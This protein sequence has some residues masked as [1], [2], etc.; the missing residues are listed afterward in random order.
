MKRVVPLEKALDANI[1][2]SKAVGLGQ[3]IR[4]GLP[5]PPGVALSGAIVEAVA[6][7]EPSAIKEVD[8]WARPLGGPLA[9]RSSAMDE[10]GA[11]ASFAGQHLTLLNVPSAEELSSALNKI[12]WSAN[13]DSAITYRQRVGLFTRPSVGVVVQAL[14]DPDTAGVMFT[15]N[16]VTGVDERVIEASW[17]LG[18]AVVAGIVI[19]DHYRLD[20]SGQ[21]LERKPGLKRVAVRTVPGGGTVEEKVAPELVERLCL[22]DEQL[23]ELNALAGR[24]EEVYGRGRDIEFAFAGG[25]LYLLQCR[26]VTRTGS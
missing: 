22:D 19:P 18:E 23:Q 20:R 4:D 9:V 21:V 6:A 8:K 12:W 7:G 5:V 2:G 24:C 15:R 11:A 25:Q 10:D 1:F 14:L 13:S 16:P 26:A 17:G 3:A